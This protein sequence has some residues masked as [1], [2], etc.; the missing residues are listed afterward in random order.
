LVTF[1][2]PL[3]CDKAASY[4][5]EMTL[6]EQETHLNSL[7]RPWQ[8]LKDG[9]A[10]SRDRQLEAVHADASIREE[11]KAEVEQAHRDNYARLIETL[12]RL[13]ERTNPK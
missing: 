8:S 7:G 6:M 3:D 10:A 4:G 1:A 11:W 5:I 13:S 12:V 9:F 2:Y